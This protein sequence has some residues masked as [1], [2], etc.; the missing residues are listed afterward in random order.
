[1]SKLSYILPFFVQISLQLCISSLLGDHT[2]VIVGCILIPI[3]F[4]S[5]LSLLI[6]FTK[7]ETSYTPT[8]EELH[9]DHATPIAVEING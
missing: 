4:I 1:M 9:F 3:V 5:L 7:I 2:L 8:T 6:R